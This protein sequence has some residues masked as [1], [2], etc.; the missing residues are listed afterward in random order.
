M[1]FGNRIY[2]KLVA[3]II[4]PVMILFSA[5]FVFLNVMIAPY[6][7]GLILDKMDAKGQ[8]RMIHL[9][10]IYQQV[11]QST[12]GIL[13][14]G[15]V[16]NTL[17]SGR[18]ASEQEPGLKALLRTY[19]YGNIYNV[20]YLT[21]DRSQMV[22]GLRNDY[23]TR[24]YL[25]MLVSHPQLSETYAKPVWVF[26]KQG[27]TRWFYLFVVQKLRHPSFN[28]EPGYLIYQLNPSGLNQ[29]TSLVMHEKEKVAITD[30]NG[31]IITCSSGNTEQEE[32]IF[33]QLEYPESGKAIT[34]EL[35]TGETYLVSR[36]ADQD[37]GWQVISYIRYSDAMER[38]E[39]LQRLIIEITVILM[40]VSVGAGFIL[41]G[42][43]I[44]PINLI[45]QAMESFRSNRFQK[46]IQDKLPDEFGQIGGTFNL[47][48]DR[49]EALIDDVNQGQEKL[50]VA[51]LNSL[52]YQINPHFIYNTLNNIYMLARMSGQEKTAQMIDY[53]SKFLRTTLSKG[54][55]VVPLKDEI[56]HVTCYLNIQKIRYGDLFDFSVEV[57]PDLSL[58]PVLKLILQ[59]IVENSINHGFLKIESGGK[60]LIKGFRCEEKL[61]LTVEDNGEGIPQEKLERLNQIPQMSLEQLSS[62][63][64]ESQGGYGVGNVIA[65]LKLY[66]G[67]DY[68][69]QYTNLNPGVKCEIFISNFEQDV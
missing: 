12:Q 50:R 15:A 30:Q 67:D 60:I 33:S 25:E 39:N 29:T 4:L 19:C 37:T 65:R 45:I 68:A 13:S 11:Y 63:F 54:K 16:Q 58:V 35:D 31:E 42:Y 26:D 27:E 57:D 64:P 56:N 8:Q 59:P 69:I 9:D 1:R 21:S 51:E 38:Y 55:S 44:K 52:M 49:I 41:T 24:G 23:L 34:C 40:V 17:M 28:V 6:L 22:S 14:D 7:E 61:C 62:L 18:I 5:F 20:I 53:L 10:G 36:F 66:Y 3:M 47:M 46:R 2:H 32:S 43:Y 48:A